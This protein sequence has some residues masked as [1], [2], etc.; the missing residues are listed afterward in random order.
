VSVLCRRGVV[1]AGFCSPQT[2]AWGITRSRDAE[3]VLKHRWV[4]IVHSLR[5]VRLSCPA[6]LAAPVEARRNSQTETV[7]QLG[8]LKRKVI[9]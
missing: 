7:C 4:W 6:K 8:L 9:R 3:M 2:D 1:Q 5:T